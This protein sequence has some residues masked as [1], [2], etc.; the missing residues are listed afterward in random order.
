LFLI[1]DPSIQ[2]SGTEGIAF[3]TIEKPLS[4]ALK[5]KCLAGWVASLDWESSR[6]HLPGFRAP[7]GGDEDRAS[8]QK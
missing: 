5:T 6:R 2:T 8:R 4:V 3:P 1:R 7:G